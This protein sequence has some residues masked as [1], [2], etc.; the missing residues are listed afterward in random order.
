MRFMVRAATESGSH[1]VVIVPPLAAGAL[2]ETPVAVE[3]RE[4][5]REIAAEYSAQV[6]DAHRM[7]E[8]YVRECPADWRLSFGKG[9]LC[10]FDLV[11]PTSKGHA[12]LADGLF[13]LLRRAEWSRTSSTGSLPPE[14]ES[15]QPTVVSP[16]SESEVVLT[17]SPPFRLQ[18]QDHGHTPVSHLIQ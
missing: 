18:P 10:H 1:V 5:L 17:F 13:E 6:L 14:F 3:Y 7:F 9:R 12:L 8:N 11:H 2:E 15:V 4:A 16:L